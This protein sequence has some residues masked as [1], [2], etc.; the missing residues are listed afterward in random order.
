MVTSHFRLEVEIWP[1]HA[2]AMK[3]MQCLLM[4]ELREFP[5][6][7]ENRGQGTRW[8]CMGQIPRSA[9]RISTGWAKKTAHY[10][11]VHIFAVHIFAKY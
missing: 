10:T 8:L 6:V 5:R 9:E 3:K 2:C 4:S 1:F 11:L 7:V